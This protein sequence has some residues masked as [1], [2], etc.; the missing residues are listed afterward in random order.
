VHAGCRCQ[1][2]RRRRRSPDAAGALEREEGARLQRIAAAAPPASSFDGRLQRWRDER[3][4]L[5][6][7]WDGSMKTPLTDGHGLI[8]SSLAP[9]SGLL[10]R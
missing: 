3:E 9:G 10:L 4:Q 5:E 2:R 6:T 8:G 7:V 1:A